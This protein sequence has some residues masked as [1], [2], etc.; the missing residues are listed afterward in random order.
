MR[1]KKTY[2]L[3]NPENEHLIELRKRP[4]WLLLLL[5][6]PLLL[7]IPFEKDIDIQTINSSDKLPI[8]NTH[9]QLSYVEKEFF[10]FQQNAF[11]TSDSIS[12]TDTTNAEGFVSFTKIRYTLY[13]WLFAHWDDAIITAQNNCFA[14]DTLLRPF[15]DLEKDPPT[16]VELGLLAFD[17]NFL[18]VDAEDNEPLPDASVTI[19]IKDLLQRN[20]TDSFTTDEAGMILIKNV[21]YCSEISVVARKWGYADSS[22]HKA[23][24]LIIGTPSPNDEM[25][26][27]T[28]PLRPL[29]DVVRFYVRSKV[30]KEAIPNALCVG[31]FGHNGKVST[32][33]TRT[34]SNG[35]GK[36]LGEFKEIRIV[37]NVDIK[38]SH[39]FYYPDSIGT[40][41]VQEFLT[42]DKEKRTIY[43]RPRKQCMTF[44]NTL[45]EQGG[46]PLAGVKNQI[47]VNGKT[48]STEI[49]NSAGEFTVCD[50]SIED[51][52]TINASKLDYISNSRTIQKRKISELI[53]LSPT[54][55]D[56]PLVKEPPPLKNYTLIL[57]RCHTDERDLYDVYLDGQKIGVYDSGDDRN[58]A[59]PPTTFSLKLAP[60]SH[61]IKL[62]MTR[63]VKG[64]CGN[65]CKIKIPT[66]LTERDINR[67]KGDR[68]VSFEWIVVV[69]I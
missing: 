39:T 17:L 55:R 21:P 8:A 37:M 58:S 42:F 69:P 3:E 11:L 10:D 33:Q 46:N 41:V 1:A 22:L 31:R 13:Q 25:N 40:F 50:L 28:L 47:I 16:I 7:L 56:I 12:L 44:R 6:L 63:E 15:F 65:H 29:K 30:T 2:I 61:T 26:K 59:L 20:R 43:L 23:G 45:N 19:S 53:D 34:N 27:R 62:V 66:L 67:K 14:S 36:I 18:V 4:W 60:G 35:T 5:L 49:S 54:Q 24:K 57:R 48:V 32:L 68:K 51:E 64:T 9:V 38:A 52:I